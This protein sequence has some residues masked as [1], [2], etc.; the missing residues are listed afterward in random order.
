MSMLRS[1][2]I[3]LMTDWLDPGYQ[4]VIMRG[5]LAAAKERDFRVV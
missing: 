2:T 4:Q 1:S 5:V 3:G